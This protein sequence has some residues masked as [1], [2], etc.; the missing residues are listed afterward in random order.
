MKR[1]RRIILTFFTVFNCGLSCAVELIPSNKTIEEEFLNCFVKACFIDTT[2]AKIQSPSL[3]KF[4]YI[5]NGYGNHW[6]IFIRDSKERIVLSFDTD[7]KPSQR[8]IMLNE[9]NGSGLKCYAI[10]DWEYKEGENYKSQAFIPAY[11]FDREAFPKYEDFFVPPFPISESITSFCLSEVDTDTNKIP[12]SK[13]VVNPD[14]ILYIAR[15]IASVRDLGP[16]FENSCVNPET[17]FGYYVKQ[18]WGNLYDSKHDKYNFAPLDNYFEDCVK[19]NTRLTLRIDQTEGA[20]DYFTIT[21]PLNWEKFVSKYI[22]FLNRHKSWYFDDDNNLLI[23]G[24]YVTCGY[25]SKLFWEQIIEE[26]NPM[27]R[28]T[29][30]YYLKDSCYVS[31]FNYNSD[32]VFKEW[33]KMQ[34]GLYKYINKKKVANGFG[35]RIKYKLL[36]EN[37]YAAVGITGEGYVGKYGVFPDDNKDFLRYYTSFSFIFKDVP[38]SYPL[39]ITYDNTHL[40]DEELQTILNIKNQLP[41]GRESYS[42]LWYDVIGLKG[43]MPYSYYTNSGISKLIDAPKDR[44]FCGEGAYN[45]DNCSQVLTHAY[46]MHLSGVSQHNI[47]FHKNNESRS[48]QQKYITLAGAKLSITNAIFDKDQLVFGIQNLGYCRVFSPYWQMIIFIRDKDGQLL[49]KKEVKYDLFDV[50]PNSYDYGEVGQYKQPS[51]KVKVPLKIPNNGAMITFAIVDKYG[52]YE[53]YW[54]HNNGRVSFSGDKSMKDGEYVIY[55]IK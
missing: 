29:Y 3:L 15:E 53:N 21:K 20:W 25:P 35:K 34:K 12:F 36:V 1:I 51:Y 47:P 38:V 27:I 6:Q 48:Q 4:S 45:D 26:N 17:H 31:F 24:V 32:C 10:I 55:K 30:N 37:L 19:Y 54:L 11:V 43:F 40:S 44:R 23:D 9:A 28:K 14:N 13:S 7:K 5:S 49:K 18:S 41:N 22:S 52:I 42:G 2:E 16:F 50:E 39:A 46:L 33:V 8:G